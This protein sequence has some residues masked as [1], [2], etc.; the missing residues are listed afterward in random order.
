MNQSTI[1]ARGTRV[2]VSGSKGKITHILSHTI[3][4]SANGK[5]RI[6]LIT[7]NNTQVRQ[8]LDIG[9]GE[10]RFVLSDVG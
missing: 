4:S 1:H 8:G 2:K 6:L 7:P 10:K 9:G 3:A 5:R